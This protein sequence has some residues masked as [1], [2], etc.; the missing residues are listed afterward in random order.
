LIRLRFVS[1]VGLSRRLRHGGGGRAAYVVA[2]IEVTDP[3]TSQKYIPGARASI[4]AHGAQMLAVDQNTDVLEG[5]APAPT[6]IFQFPDR[7]TAEAWY[8]SSEY[9]SIIHLRLESAKSRVVIADGF[10]PSL[11]PVGAEHLRA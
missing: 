4:E 8:H 11:A 3:E 6:I 2:S 5:A 1:T 7:A 9:Q 10:V